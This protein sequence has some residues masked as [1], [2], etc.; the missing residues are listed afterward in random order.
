MCIQTLYRQTG[1]LTI[2][3]TT[4]YLETLEGAPKNE[5]PIEESPK[6]ELIRYVSLVQEFLADKAMTAPNLDPSIHADLQEI[7]AKEA[8]A[9]GGWSWNNQAQLE[10]SGTYIL[11]DKGRYARL[12]TR[13]DILAMGSWL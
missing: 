13:H 12:Y 6:S 7:A 11:L 10:S 5:E 1:A 8:H 3:G 4:L 2:S 9:L